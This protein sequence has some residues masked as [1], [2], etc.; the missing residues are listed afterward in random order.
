MIMQARED[1]GEPSLRIDVVEL[2]GL[3]QRVDHGGAVAALVG[4]GEG[5]VLAAHGDRTNLPLGRIVGHADAAIV[6]K[7]CE[8]HPAGESVSDGLADLAL[9]GPFSAVLG[10][11]SLQGGHERAAA[12][13]AYALARM[14]RQ[15]VDL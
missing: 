15:S 14:W 13:G 7:A 8:R 12:H 11:P 1:V 9:A 5:P 3:D 10:H 6:E 2:G 4:A